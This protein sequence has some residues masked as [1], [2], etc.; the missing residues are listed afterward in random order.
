MEKTLEKA[1]MLTRGS[2]HPSSRSVCGWKG[3]YQGSKFQALE[4]SMLEY[5]VETNGS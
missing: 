4:G 5:E 2:L 1:F 3:T